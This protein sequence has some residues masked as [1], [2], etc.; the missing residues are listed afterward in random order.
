MGV[1]SIYI[2]LLENKNLSKFLYMYLQVVQ[3]KFYCNSGALYRHKYYLWHLS[4]S[5]LYWPNFMQSIIWSPSLK[6]CIMHPMYTIPQL[7]MTMTLAYNCE[8]LISMPPAPCRAPIG[9]TKW[10]KILM[11]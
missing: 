8:F 10:G 1:I 7:N 6:Y 3:Q 4:R 2:M 11:L 9:I 5:T